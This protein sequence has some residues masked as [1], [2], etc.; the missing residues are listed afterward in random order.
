MSNYSLDSIKA[1]S[2]VGQTGSNASR[3]GT[4]TLVGET[5][6]EQVLTMKLESPLL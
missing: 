4:S 5:L 3:I 6:L 2:T 1:K